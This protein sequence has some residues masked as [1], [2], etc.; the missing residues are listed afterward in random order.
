MNF[1]DFLTTIFNEKNIVKDLKEK[2]KIILFGF[3]VD[4]KA[5]IFFYFSNFSMLDNFLYFSIVEK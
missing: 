5:P 3:E 2:A 1:E 4:F